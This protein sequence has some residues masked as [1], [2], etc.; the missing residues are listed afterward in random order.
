MAGDQ[1]GLF[2]PP[3]SP[4]WTQSRKDEIDRAFRRFHDSNP[5]IWWLFVRFTFDAIR[6]GRKNYG[7]SAVIGF[8]RV[9]RRTSEDLLPRGDVDRAWPDNVT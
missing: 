6:S 5:G 2:G 4:D 3:R 7:V 8:F 9:R 1:L